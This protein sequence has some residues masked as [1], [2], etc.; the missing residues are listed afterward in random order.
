[1]DD[2]FISYSRKDKAFVSRLHE[3]LKA[4]QRGAWMDLEDIPPTAEWR[5]RTKAGI[6][7]A[8]AFVFVLSPDSIRS[9]E[10]VLSG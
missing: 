2:I 8:R 6:E 10:S 7:G 1:M 5:E 4:R 9:P 3:A